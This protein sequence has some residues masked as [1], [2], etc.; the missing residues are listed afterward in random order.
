[1]PTIDMSDCECCD[2]VLTNCCGNTVSKN[3]VVTLH[4]NAL[5]A[6]IEGLTI[7]IEWDGVRWYGEASIC[8]AA[9]WFAILRCT[10]DVWELEINS[11]TCIV[12]DSDNPDPGFSCD[13]F[14]ATFGPFSIGTP[15]SACCCAGVGAHTFNAQVT[16]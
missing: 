15:L 7:P 3:L 4:D 16:E 11:V 8:S 2:R 13:P 14:D 12:A 5:C 1:M 6:G 9:D 10:G